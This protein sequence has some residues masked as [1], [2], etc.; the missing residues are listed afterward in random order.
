MTRILIVG[1]SYIHGAV[2]AETFRLWANLI[3][4]LNP[5]TDVL[6]VDSASPDLPNDT[7]LERSA[8]CMQLGDNIGHMSLNGKDGWGRA[9]SA[10]VRYAIEKEYDWL[11]NIDCDLLFARPVAEVI[12]KMREFGVRA[13]APMAIPYNFTETALSF[14]SV[15]YLRETDLIGKYDWEHPRYDVIPEQRIDMI[16][17]DTMFALPLR[18][19]RNDAKATADQLP[20]IFAT[21]IDWIHH[22]ELPVLKAFIRMNGHANII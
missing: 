1:T 15:D 3:A 12:G 19:F 2:A 14:W 7:A 22:A 10:G 21:G 5:G 9:F 18:G 11:V 4:K 6:I 8:T 16:C 17:A 13:A 20:R